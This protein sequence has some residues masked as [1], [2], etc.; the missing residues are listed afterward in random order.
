MSTKRSSS[1]TAS[2]ASSS[3]TTVARRQQPRRST[4]KSGVVFDAASVTSKPLL[5]R[6]QSR[7]T[8][9]S[10]ERSRSCVQL[11]PPSARRWRSEA[12]LASTTAGSGRPNGSTPTT[13]VDADVI[14]TVFSPRPDCGRRRRQEATLGRGEHAGRLPITSCSSTSE[15]IGK[16]NCLWFSLV[17]V[18]Q[19]NFFLLIRNKK[20]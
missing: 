10:E 13:T 17:L 18:F 4:D 14:E 1:T 15:K 19:I 8:P 5:R 3:T 6:L 9:T 20:Q 12:H 16:P 11:L 2:S 7:S